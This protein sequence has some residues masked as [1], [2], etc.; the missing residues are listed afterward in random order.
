MCARV[1]VCART[2]KMLTPNSV[3]SFRPSC[4][5][6]LCWKLPQIVSLSSAGG[7]ACVGFTRML[8]ERDSSRFF[9]S[10]ISVNERSAAVE[11][12]RESGKRTRIELTDGRAAG[13]VLLLQHLVLLVELVEV[14]RN[15]SPDQVYIDRFRGIRTCDTSRSWSL[16]VVT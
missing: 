5:P 12:G 3:L 10:A 8:C 14:L 16:S 13:V 4:L 6:D 2:L 15:V 1:C 11:C 7:S 9:S